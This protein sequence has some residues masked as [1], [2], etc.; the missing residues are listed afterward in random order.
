LS[1][2]ESVARVMVEG[3]EESLIEALARRIGQAITSALNDS[4]Y[5][6]S[7]TRAKE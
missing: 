3:P 1:G 4:T 7:S 5:D 2:T 6:E